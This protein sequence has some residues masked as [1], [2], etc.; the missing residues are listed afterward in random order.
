MKPTTV[1][2]RFALRRLVDF[3]I[4]LSTNETTNESVH[5]TIAFATV[6]AIALA[7]VAI[8][9]WLVPVT[10]NPAV[11]VLLWLVGVLAGGGF[12]V[13]GLRFVDRKDGDT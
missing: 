1:S 2:I 8:L 12:L 6:G 5:R 4:N 9:A 7:T 3:A 13:V 11:Q 10:S